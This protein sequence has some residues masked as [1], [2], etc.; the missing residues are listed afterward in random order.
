MCCEQNMQSYDSLR[1]SNLPFA[2]ASKKFQP[3]A[4]ATA[5][6]LAV[7]HFEPVFPFW[8]AGYRAVY[9]QPPPLRPFYH[10]CQ[11]EQLQRST[12]GPALPLLGTGK[13]EIAS[14][15]CNFLN[16]CSVPY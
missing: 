10:S 9:T 11:P 1:V 3:G 14:F 7:G 12:K 6:F 5:L 16:T 2:A 13:P 8:Q 15:S 4:A